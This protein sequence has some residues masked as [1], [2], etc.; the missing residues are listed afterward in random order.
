VLPEDSG[1]KV[2][3][4]WAEFVVFVLFIVYRIFTYVNKVFLHSTAFHG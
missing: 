1:G 2:S 4:G 3:V